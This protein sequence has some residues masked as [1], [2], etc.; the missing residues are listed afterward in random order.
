MGGLAGAHA[1][2]P[3]NIIL[4]LAD[5][6]GYDD[7]SCYGAT[8]IKTP[9]IDQLAAEGRRFTSYYAPGAVCT[10][11]RAA[12]M[13]GCYAQR[14]GLPSVLYPQSNIGLNAD[15]TTIAELLRSRGYA[16]ACIGKWHLG[17][18]PQFLPNNHGFDYFFGLPYPNDHG[19][20]RTNRQN[21]PIPLWRNEEIIEQPV[22]LVSLNDR[23]VDEAKKF[24]ADHREQPFFLYLPFV[25]A[26]TPWY[27]ADRFKG[28]SQLSP[29]G[30]AVQAMDW[31]VGEVMQELKQQNLDNNTL[32]VFASDNGPL[33]VPHPGLEEAYGEAGRLLPQTHLLREGK[34]SSAEGGVRV[35]MI[36]RWPGRIPAKTECHELAAGFDLYPTFAALA[37]AP[38]PETPLPESSTPTDRPIDGKN[39]LPLLTDAGAKTPHDRFYYFADY[40]LEGVR[41]GP[42]KLRLVAHDSIAPHSQQ[43]R[44]VSLYN[45]DDDVSESKNLAAK[46]PEIVAE[47]KQLLKECR[48]DL[49]DGKK[50]RPSRRPPGKVG[51]EPP[52][53]N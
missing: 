16:T 32:V 29:Y 26:H 4:L 46:H 51:D 49:G 27:V 52:R 43:R 42:W 35:P 5:D 2:P 40:K 53:S 34:Y 10:P 9:N 31:A 18:V 50:A 12:L 3:P 24:I 14:V 1:A 37:E 7:L 22:D 19:P 38:L 11:T 23:F 25:D 15:E 30:D 39:I 6:V 41:R 21:P 48:A 33:W 36:A 28:M 47:L 17:H 44:G 20:E 45:L 13:T 8:K